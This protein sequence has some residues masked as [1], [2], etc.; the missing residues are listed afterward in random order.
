[1]NTAQYYPWIKD[2]IRGC[3]S[4][5]ENCPAVENS[6]LWYSSPHVKISPIFHPS[7]L[8]FQK[9]GIENFSTPFVNKGETFAAEENTFTETLIYF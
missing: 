6:L 5:K 3:S 9:E 7:L 1:M 2:K 8:C 4:V